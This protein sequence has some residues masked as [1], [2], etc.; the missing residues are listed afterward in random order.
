MLQVLRDSMKYLAWIL[1]VVIGIFVLFVFVDFGRAGRYASGSPTAAA[2]TVAG[3]PITRM[4]Y[5][6]E[7]Q[8]LDD[9]MRQQLGAQYSE[10]LVKQLRL[11]QQAL[12]QLVSNK[13]LLAE[14]NDLDLAV[15][16]R[17]LRRYIVHLPFLQDSEGK[18]IGAERY[19]LMVRR[20]GY[21][22]DAFEQEVREELM[23][24]RLR[25]ALQRSVVVSDQDVEDHYREQNEKVKLRYVSVPFAASVGQVQVSD[26]DLQ[27]YFDAHREQYRVPEQRIADYLLVDQSK[28][29]QSIAPTEAEL[30]DYY[31][32]HQQEYAQPEQVR[33]RHILVKTEEEAAAAKK[34]LDSGEDFAKV[35]AA[36][37]TDSSN[38]KTGGDLGWFGHGRMVPAFDQAAFAAP[39]GKVVGPV[40]TEF[41]YHLIRVD[42]KRAASATPFDEVQQ[43]VRTRLAAERAEGQA[44]E[45]AKTYAADLAKAG[46]NARQKM[47]ELS[48]QPGV[49]I[50]KTEAFSRQGVV[51][52]L[53][54]APAL[55]TAAFAL[56]KGGVSAPLRTPRGWVVL[57]VSDVKPPRVPQL[58]EVREAVRR[59]AEQDKQREQA[60]AR[61]AAA[62]AKAGAGA[63]LDAVAAQLGVGVQESPEFGRTGVIP[64]IGY[65]PDLV[66]AAMDSPVGAVAG[67]MSVA[68]SALLYQVT[69]K[70]GFDPAQYAQQKDSMRAQLEQEQVNALLTSLINERRQRLGV[71][72]DPQLLEELGMAQGTPKA[73]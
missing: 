33:A 65:A 51:A 13:I 3:Q 20:L 66:K 2:A 26:A 50:G 53:G 59:G 1:W 16:D 57:Q 72:Y 37:S 52:P 30:R 21:T 58:A 22:P 46:A 31:A 48:T 23:L 71:T 12:N 54:S 4:E 39:I 73:G 11:P 40:K 17:E 9:R 10:D 25:S 63:A 27:R 69:A 35:A 19:P 62:R 45:K 8:R 68:G 49:E 67:P 47:Q 6:R 61:L 64:G 44:E 28:L 36:V 18:F 15:S 55:N 38:A 7:K 56:Q 24:Q 5:E 60:F 32:Q 42:E 29:E 70:T 34:R 14:A 43:A 41:G